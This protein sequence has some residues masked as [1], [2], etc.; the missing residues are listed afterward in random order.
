MDNATEPADVNAALVVS[1]ETRQQEEV[2][3]LLR[4]HGLRSHVAS[5]VRVV[6]LHPG[7]DAVAF[8]NELR[9]GELDAM[10]AMTPTAVR[11]LRDFLSPVMGPNELLRLLP[12]VIVAARGT[13][14]YAAL[15][16]LGVRDAV[17]SRPPHTYRELA[18][19]AAERIRIAGSRVAVL[20]GGRVHARLR[21]LLME[22]GAE[23]L[24]VAIYHT[25]PP[26]DPQPLLDAVRSINRREVDGALFT[27]HTQVD[28]LMALASTHQLHADLVAS[29][30][31]MTVVCLGT[32]SRDRLLAHGV[33]VHMVETEPS[34][35]DGV[36][37]LVERLAEAQEEGGD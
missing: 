2:A 14:T 16:K 4:A 7:P 15:T 36:E 19:A 29:L 5:A 21:G 10:L 22:Q 6:P 28:H 12:N 34:L 20:E 24:Q 35:A 17:T 18:S 30:N 37:L 13:Q 11:L 31:A 33:Q 23:V 27:N 25:A 26:E 3:R 9:T 1:F 32:S 8:A